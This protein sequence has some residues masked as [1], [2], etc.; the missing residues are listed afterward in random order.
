MLINQHN[1]SI[2][3]L[4]NIMKITIH[5]V[6]LKTKA[7]LTESPD[8]HCT[9]HVISYIAVSGPGKQPQGWSLLGD[10]VGVDPGVVVVSELSFSGMFCGG[11]LLFRCHVWR[12]DIESDRGYRIKNTGYISV[13]PF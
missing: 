9:I 10:E 2:S 13:R 3:K 8:S 11:C 12:W 7:N 4:S 1:F 5:L 6:G